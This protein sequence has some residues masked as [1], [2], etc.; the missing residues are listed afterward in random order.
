MSDSRIAAALD[1]AFTYAQIDGAH[2]KAWAIDQMVR[3]LTGCPRVK[4]KAKDYKGV[5]YE[6]ETLGESQEYLDWVKN[7][8]REGD[9]P[10][11]YT[12]E[13]GTPP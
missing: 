2:H 11:A 8:S 1:K 6:Y 13:T 12:W 9:D 7:Y 5:E 10:E 4:V 3:E